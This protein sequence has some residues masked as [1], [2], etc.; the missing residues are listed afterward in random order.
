MSNTIGPPPLG[1]GWDETCPLTTDAHGNA[2]YEIR[3]LRMGLRIRMNKE[4]T[5]LGASSAG[6]EHKPGSA[7]CWIQATA[8]TV[9]PDG[10]TA[11]TVADIGRVWIDTTNNV[12]KALTAVGSPNTWTPIGQLLLATYSPGSEPTR[13]LYMKGNELYFKGTDTVEKLVGGLIDEDDMVSD[14]AT[15]CPSQ[16]SVKAFGATV[17]AAA[18]G[19][20]QTYTDDSFDA[21]MIDEDDMASDSDTRLPTQQSVKAYVDNTVKK[22]DSGW[23]A[24]AANTTYT[25]AHGL[26]AVPTIVQVWYSDTADGTGDVHVV[27]GGMT[28][29]GASGVSAS[30]IDIDATDIKVYVRDYLAYYYEGYS[31]L[32]APTSGYLKVVALLVA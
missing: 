20:A 26:G 6:C 24:A 9:R 27:D 17:Q 19:A 23:F 7:V 11:L 5:T 28:T 2:M 25:K 10:T 32:N 8:P 4:H 1:T 15:R 29:A 30:T 12:V 3:D 31:V 16:Q 21:T 18:L 22:Y 13:G 14:S